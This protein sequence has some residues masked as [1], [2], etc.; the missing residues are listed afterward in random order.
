MHHHNQAFSTSLN[1]LINKNKQYA[2]NFKIWD[3]ME[4]TTRIKWCMAD[5]LILQILYPM[6]SFSLNHNS[7]CH[8]S[9]RNSKKIISINSSLKCLWCS[10]LLCLSNSDNYRIIVRPISILQLSNNP[11]ISLSRMVKISI[12]SLDTSLEIPIT[13]TKKTTIQITKITKITII[14]I[15]RSKK[16]CL[17]L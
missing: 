10:N 15:V 17:L 5:F 1:S 13:P 6:V 4:C 3:R 16:K 12:T 14:I 9:H 8:Q 2:I 7:Q 11:S